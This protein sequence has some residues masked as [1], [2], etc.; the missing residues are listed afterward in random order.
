[1]K[2]IGM[3]NFKTALAVFLCI[4]LLRFF[5]IEYPFYACIAAVICMQSSV[6]DS[7]T[8][9]KNRMEGTFI[10]ALL[11]LLFALVRPGNA[12]LCAIGIVIIIHI[13]NVINRKKSISIACIVFIAI[14][15]NLKDTSAILYSTN[16]LLETFLGIAISVLVNY[17]IY[18]PNYYKKLYAMK[19]K[20]IDTQYNLLK[21]HLCLNMPIELNDIH[22]E[23][24]NFEILFNSFI[25]EIPLKHNKSSQVENF[26]QLLHL[27]KEIYSHFY[28][29]KTMDGT[30]SL[31]DKNLNNLMEL[32]NLHIENKHPMNSDIEI[33][34]NYHIEKLIYLIS[35]LKNTYES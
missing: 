30:F 28:M 22:T 6:V 7:F 15:T 3:R 35:L 19:G 21:N 14:M 10:G 17:F 2:E 26:K 33:V 31:N 25:S 32:F 11:G 24:N 13:C 1:M 12:L 27:S 8:M 9:G 23:I 20:L 5:K 18:P 34:Y 16:R 4:V 29:L